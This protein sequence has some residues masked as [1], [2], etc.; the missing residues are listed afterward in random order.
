LLAQKETLQ[1]GDVIVIPSIRDQVYVKGEVLKP[2]PFPYLANYTAR[3]YAGFA[4]LLE[5]SKGLDNIYVIHTRTGE[6]EKGADVIVG[7]G[8]IVVVPRR[9]REVFKDY[10]SVLMP[11]ISVGLSAYALIRTSG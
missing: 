11:I 1:T 4:G 10:L 5:T 7:N 6:I 8:D 9:S 2:G 3:D